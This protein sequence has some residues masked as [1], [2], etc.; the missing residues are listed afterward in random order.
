MGRK[1][2]S[3]ITDEQGAIIAGLNSLKYEG[4]WDGDHL[5]DSFHILQNTKKKLH[6]KRNIRIFS[7]LVHAENKGI[8]EHIIESSMPRLTDHDQAVLREFMDEAH[9]YCFSQIPS[10]F[11]GFSVCSSIVEKINDLIKSKIPV[12]KPFTVVA[13]KLLD[14]FDS[15]II[16][17]VDKQKPDREKIHK[18]FAIP[19]IWKLNFLVGQK[20]YQKVT[21]QISNSFYCMLRVMEVGFNIRDKY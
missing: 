19:E 14:Y 5:L 20:L 18:Y 6:Q 15:K 13:K 8:Y 1:P 3:I 7:D 10:N 17:D 12:S 16:H 2:K 9:K 4:L 21:L 11:V